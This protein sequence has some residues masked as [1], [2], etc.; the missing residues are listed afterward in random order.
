M[1][2][3]IAGDALQRPLDIVSN[4]SDD[5]CYVINESCTSL[6]EYFPDQQL[7]LEISDLTLTQ[8]GGSVLSNCSQRIILTDKS[9]FCA[10]FHL[11]EHKLET[12]RFEIPHSEQ[13]ANE[14][15]PGGVCIDKDGFVYVTDVNNNQVLVFDSSMNYVTKLSTRTWFRNVLGTLVVCDARV[16]GP[17][18][19]PV[20]V[21]VMS[22]GLLV[23]LEQAGRVKVF[24]HKKKM[25]VAWMRERLLRGVM[26][27][28]SHKMD[29][30][31]SQLCTVL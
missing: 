27:G 23:V 30:L 19:G 10:I 31:C 7:L 16:A 12:K 26:G 2:F 6:H 21:T 25:N 1:T 13:D 29:T 18:S 28:G 5:T 20:D 4:P 3:H 22:S 17:I 24:C 11:D 9:G 8:Y 14:Y 15:S